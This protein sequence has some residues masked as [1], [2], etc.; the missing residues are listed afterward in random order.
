MTEPPEPRRPEEDGGEET[1]WDALERNAA[2][3]FVADST[4]DMQEAIDAA[5]AEYGDE[6]F[7]AMVA[8]VVRRAN[9]PMRYTADLEELQDQESLDEID[10]DLLLDAL[11]S[12]EDVEGGTLTD[13]LEAWRD[14]VDSVPPPAGTAPEIIEQIHDFTQEI[15]RATTPPRPTSEGS[16]SSVSISEDAARIRQ[17]ADNQAGMQGLSGGSI[18]FAEAVSV[19]IRDN[20]AAAALA[21]AAEQLNADRQNAVNLLGSGEGAQA[22]EGAGGN[23]AEAVQTALNAVSAAIAKAD[24]AAAAIESAQSSIETARGNVGNFYNTIRDAASR[25]GG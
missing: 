9:D 5:R 3:D 4:P 19:Q 21:G 25:H 2:R 24:E 22:V 14:D 1:D 11:G 12:G 18:S 10:D 6:A 8:E 23:A 16:A 20:D 13:T 15:D 17:I 7:D